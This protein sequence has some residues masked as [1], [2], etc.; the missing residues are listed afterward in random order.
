M[1][2]YYEPYSNKFDNLDKSHKFFKY[3]NNQSSL[4]DHKVQTAWPRASGPVL[5]TESTRCARC[6]R[7]LTSRTHSPGKGT[8]SGPLHPAG[9]QENHPERE[10]LQGKHVG[11]KLM[12]RKG[13]GGLPA[14]S[15]SQFLGDTAVRRCSL[16]SKGSGKSVCRR[17]AWLEPSRGR[18]PLPFLLWP[19]LFSRAF[20]Q[21]LPTLMCR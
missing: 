13:S 9:K 20:R 3:S 11:P 7:S 8:G 10:M 5:G 12:P 2:T 19:S 4:I 18:S 21:A 15:K 17:G 6:Q 14:Q 1:R 16:K